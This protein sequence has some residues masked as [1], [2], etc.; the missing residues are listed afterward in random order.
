MLKTTARAGLQSCPACRVFSLQSSAKTPST[1]SSSPRPTALPHPVLDLS[2]LL[3]NP[4][5]FKR[6]LANRRYPL[7]PSVVDEIRQ[8]EL[9]SV[10]LRKEIQRARERRNAVSSGTGQGGKDAREVAKAEGLAVKTLLKTLEPRL[11]QLT[12]KLQSLAIQLP[13]TSHPSSPIGSEDC[14]KTVKTHG[15][16]ISDPPPH[17][18]PRR[19]H[20][21]LSS[22]ANLAWTDFPSAALVTGS[23]WPYLLNDGALLELALTNYAVSVALRRGFKPVLTPDVIRS[24]VAERCGFRPRDGEAQQTYFLSDGVTSS[25][26]STLCLAGTAEIPLVGMAAA[27]TFKSSDLPLRRVGLGR[28]FRAEAGARGADSRGLYRVHQFSKVEMVVICSDEDSHRLLEELR[29]VQ[30]EILSSL[31][32][33]LRSV[34]C[35]FRD[36]MGGLKLTFSG[37]GR[38]LEMP[39]EELGAS[40]HRKYDIEAWMPGRGKWGEV[41]VS[42]HNE[43]EICSQSHY[44]FFL[45]MILAIISVQL[46]RLPVAKTWYSLPPSFIRR[47][48]ASTPSLP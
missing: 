24:D 36:C 10:D 1:S 4:E 29:D 37:I 41:R 12:I 40:A 38:V 45:N 15:P 22:P 48:V 44:H 47:D 39:T 33:S 26:D 46:H 3:S 32:L 17:A 23:S 7:A 27:T 5:N 6:N 16:A 42:L 31:G 34:K 2:S 9:D 19:E 43:A 25:P 14:A 30:E 35:F 28:A 21:Q 20:L 18:D 11:A 8:L 13:N